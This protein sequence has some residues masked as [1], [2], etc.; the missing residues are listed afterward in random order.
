VTGATYDAANQQ[1]SFNGQPLTFDLNGNLTGDGTNTYTWNARDEL[2]AINGTGLTASFLYDGTGRRQRK[3]LDGAQ[4][5]FLY[6]GMNPVQETRA[7][8][9]AALLTGLEIDSHLLRTDA[10]GTVALLADALGSTVALTDATGTETTSYTFEPFGTTTP[11][12][13]ASDNAFQYTGR[14][15]DGTGLYYYRARYYHPQLQRFTAEDRSGPLH[16][17]GRQSLCVCLE[18]PRPIPR[19]ARGGRGGCNR[20]ELRDRSSETGWSCR[21]IVVWVGVVR[22]RLPRDTRR[23]LHVCR[24]IRDPYDQRRANGHRCVCGLRGWILHHKCHER[25]ADSRCII[26]VVRR[27]VGGAVAHQ[28]LVEH[29]FLRQR[30]S[31]CDSDLRLGNRDR[32]VADVNNNRA[33]ARFAVRSCA[34]Q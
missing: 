30:D 14:E 27:R 11:S 21:L 19:S 31:R 15:N 34:S 13:A 16:G 29:Q 25:R 32:S 20:R 8:G 24:R 28:R 9:T 2:V 7:S 33:C 5:E 23:R 12:G 18:C 4:T 22:R 26:Y 3:T 1:V 17:W 10:V 6:D